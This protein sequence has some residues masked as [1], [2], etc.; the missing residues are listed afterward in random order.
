MNTNSS[1]L[2]NRER[3]VVKKIAE[4]FSEEDIRHLRKILDDDDHATWL[5]KRVWRFMAWVGGVLLGAMTLKDWI[6][7]AYR[8]IARP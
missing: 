3:R 7:I 5:R 8:W 4:E 2:D 6:A 1:D